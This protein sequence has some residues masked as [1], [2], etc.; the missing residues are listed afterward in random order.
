MLL[1]LLQKVLLKKK[2]EKYFSFKLK[3]QEIPRK[4]LKLHKH[5][6]NLTEFAGTLISFRWHVNISLKTPSTAKTMQILVPGAQ[7]KTG[8]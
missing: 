4:T 3:T 7:A 6:C 5:P 1:W 2:R 8:R